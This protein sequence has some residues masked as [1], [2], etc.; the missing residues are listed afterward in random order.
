M[1][2][3]S[4]LGG[5]LFTTSVLAA[6]PHVKDGMLVDEQGMTLYVFGRK[7][8]P[9]AL[10]VVPAAN[11]GSQWT[12]QGKPLFRGLMDKRPGDRSGDGPNEV[13]HSVQIH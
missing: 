4:I 3:L 6:A 7:G 9:G 5:F 13:W 2:T 12:F 10:T 11:D 1:K 8:M